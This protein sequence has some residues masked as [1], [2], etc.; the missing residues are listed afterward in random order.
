MGPRHIAPKTREHNQVRM[1]LSFRMKP[2][3]Q[4]LDRSDICVADRL[5]GFKHSETL[6]PEAARILGK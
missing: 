1:I 3:V 5:G 4:M 2:G 6:A